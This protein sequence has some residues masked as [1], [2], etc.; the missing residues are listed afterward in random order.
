MRRVY[1]AITVHTDIVSAEARIFSGLAE[2]V[3]VT[4]DMGELGIFPGHTALITAI[5]P[6]QIRIRLQGGRE[7]LYY[8]SG[9]ILEVQP[10][11]VTILADTVVRA[12][13]LVE[14]QAL[15]AKMEAERIL[16]NRKAGMNVTNAII[17]LA[18]AIAQLRT[19]KLQ[20]SK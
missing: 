10:D 18:Q 9:G 6:G 19:I 7:D 20:S 17:Q 2:M 14:A 16:A 1:M 8:V 15:E 5:K 12:E 4:G 13:N 11:V 3:V